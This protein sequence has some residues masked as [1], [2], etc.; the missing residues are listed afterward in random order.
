MFDPHEH[1]HPDV[2]DIDLVEI[3]EYII[4]DNPDAARAVVMA[5]RETFILLAGQPMLGTDYNPIRRVLRGIRMFTVTAYPNYLIYY[6]PLPDNTGV[7]ILYV[8]HAARDAATFAHDYQ[9]Q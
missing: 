8:L 9:R 2:E 7:R 3:A 4:P 1:M 6:R 5:I